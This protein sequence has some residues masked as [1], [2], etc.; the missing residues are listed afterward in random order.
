[1][2]HLIIPGGFLAFEVGIDQVDDVARLMTD[3]GF[4]V[5]EMRKDLGGIARTVVAQK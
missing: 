5:L 4:K 3:A 1:M 2:P